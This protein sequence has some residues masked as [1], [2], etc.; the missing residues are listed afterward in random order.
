MTR[1]CSEKHV[2]HLSSFSSCEEEIQTVLVPH[3]TACA[4]PMEFHAVYLCMESDQELRGT[5][6]DGELARYLLASMSPTP[7]SHGLREIWSRKPHLK[8]LGASK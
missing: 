4:L 2:G 3:L 6:Q 8:I 7:I 5:V 1:V